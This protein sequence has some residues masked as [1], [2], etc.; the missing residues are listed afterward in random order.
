METVSSPHTR[1]YFKPFGSIKKQHHFHKK[2]EHIHLVTTTMTQS[3]LLSNR[4]DLLINYLIIA[5]R[6]LLFI[7]I[8]YIPT[9]KNGPMLASAE[10]FH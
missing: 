2:H 10:C 9:L 8:D 1:D 4:A 6:S 5:K 3:S 7:G